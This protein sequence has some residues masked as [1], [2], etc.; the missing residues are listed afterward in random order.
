MKEKLS[1]LSKFHHVIV[2]VVIHST[3]IAKC[4]KLKK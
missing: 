1:G 3:Q 4:D 2:N